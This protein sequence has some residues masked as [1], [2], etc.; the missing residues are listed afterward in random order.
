[1]R[2]MEY[3]LQIQESLTQDAEG[4]VWSLEDAVRILQTEMH[5]LG[6][7]QREFEGKIAALKESFQKEMAQAVKEKEKNAGA[8]YAKDVTQLKSTIAG[9]Q[10]KIGVLEAEGK[11]LNVYVDFEK[12]DHERTRQAFKKELAEYKARGKSTSLLVE[13]EVHKLT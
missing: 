2:E 10:A 7:L 4:E 8:V 1:M 3:R 9:L 5:S 6:Q 11:K 13:A 12:S